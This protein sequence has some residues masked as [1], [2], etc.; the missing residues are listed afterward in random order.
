MAEAR[1]KQLRAA[2]LLGAAHRQWRDLGG[3]PDGAG[4][5]LGQHQECE[6]AARAGLGD[7]RFEAE[8]ARGGDLARDQAVAY[9]LGE[10]QPSG[11]AASAAAATLVLTPREREI[12]GL[13]ADGLTNREIAERL[14]IS[15]RTAESHVENILAKLGFASRTQIVAWILQ[16]GEKP[17]NS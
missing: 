13:V 5:W 8:F 4:A 10:D 12:A 11:T 6:R 1:G 14:V 16:N 2:C 15:R 7:A 9:A 17:D 3:N